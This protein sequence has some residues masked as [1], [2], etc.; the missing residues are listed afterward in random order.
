[1]RLCPKCNIECKKHQDKCPICGG[2]VLDT[3]ESREVSGISLV[4][5]PKRVIAIVLA[6]LGLLIALALAAVFVIMKIPASE[7]ALYIKD[8]DLCICIANEEPVIIEE[9]IFKGVPENLVETA[10]GLFERYVFF[11]REKK[12]IVYPTEFDIEDNATDILDSYIYDSVI[13]DDIGASRKFKIKVSDLSKN[14]K[15]VTEE[16]FDLYYIAEDSALLYRENDSLYYY[17]LID[18]E[19]K[20]LCDDIF[21]LKVNEEKG[22]FMAFIEG[23]NIMFGNSDSVYDVKCEYNDFYSAVTSLAFSDSLG[24]MAYVKDSDELYFVSPKDGERKIADDVDYIYSVYDTGEIYYSRNEGFISPYSDYVKDDVKDEALSDEERAKVQEIRSLIGNG[25]GSSFYKVTLYYYDGENESTLT[26]QGVSLSSM[27]Q[28]STLHSYMGPFDEPLLF[29]NR[30]IGKKAEKLLVSDLLH[31]NDPE[32]YISEYQRNALMGESENL[33]AYKGKTVKTE[34]FTS[35]YAD[36]KGENF[37]FTQNTENIYCNVYRAKVKDGKM[38]TPE[39]AFEKV[40]NVNTM[41]LESGELLYFKNYGSHNK[42][43]EMYIGDELID[44]NVRAESVFEIGDT[45]YWLCDYD[46][47]SDAGTLMMLKKGEKKPV[48]YKVNEDSI[49]PSKKGVFYIVRGFEKDIVYYFN[50]RKIKPVCEEADILF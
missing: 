4:K 49:R 3:S 46:R 9:D 5:I 1:M 2:A 26:E 37:Y 13:L 12:M 33:I 30:A 23:D 18:D 22:N 48:A 25:S 40:Y 15:T 39:L 6:S 35:V 11:D 34:R 14:K 10:Q 21:T 41:V 28:G 32:R 42:S 19:K 17:S 36:S 47:K 45:L 8:G 29:Y 31:V 24:S 38:S 20:K 44:K 16:A 50:G 27:G 7:P 43:G